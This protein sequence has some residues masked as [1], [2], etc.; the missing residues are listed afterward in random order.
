ML[1]PLSDD[2]DA[3][4]ALAAREMLHGGDKFVL[5][6]NG[7]RY[8][9]KPPLQYWLV[10]ACYSVLGVNEFATHLPSALSVILLVLLLYYFGREYFGWRAGLYAGLAACTSLGMFVYTR[11]MIPE[12]LYALEFTLFFYLFL[13]GWTGRISPGLACRSCA[14]LLAL[15]VLTRGLIGLLLPVMG[16]AC[17]LLLTGAWTRCREVP[18]KSC[19][20]ILLALALPW[21]IVVQVRAPRFFWFYFVNEHLLRAIGARY[22]HDTLGLPLLFWW[23]A[24]LVWFFPWIFFLPLALRGFPR[25]STWR[26]GLGAG[27]HARLLLLSWAA[28]VL[29]FFSITRTRSEYYSFGAWPAIALLIGAGIARAEEQNDSW[30][31][32]AQAALAGVGVVIACGLGVWFLA[33]SAASA[34]GN[35]TQMVLLKG[36]PWYQPRIAENFVALTKPM[37]GL[38]GPALVAS[39]SLLAG[40]WAAFWFRRR[41]PSIQG[42]YKATLAV[43]A[44][45]AG[46]LCSAGWAHAVLAPYL[47]SRDLAREVRRQLRP[48][49]LVATYGDFYLGSSFAFY[50]NR[51]LLLYDGRKNSLE[52][53]SHDPDAPPIFYSDA[54]FPRLWRGPQRVFLFLSTDSRSDVLSRLPSE[55]TYLLE[56]SGGKAVYVNRPVE[57]MPEPSHAG[58][59]SPS[60]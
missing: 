45:M 34:G 18:W 15:A 8:L 4:H 30:L 33:P 19:V 44:G 43:A 49:D 52:F 42:G 23:A 17:F 28:A 53:G 14:V 58:T 56:E 9:E 35:L 55:N 39:C 60:E 29:V 3:A 21:H 20:L 48:T 32:R 40:V 38:R 1:S 41:N 22:P 51:Q 57:P 59:G 26:S 5:H 36:I 13:E 54:D 24:H 50:L 25:P 31:P 27:D 10:A 2:V 6:I 12:P 11:T 37:T 16:V 46:L 7:I 47:S